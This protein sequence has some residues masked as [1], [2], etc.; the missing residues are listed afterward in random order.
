AA[1]VLF[2]DRSFPGRPVPE[3]SLVSG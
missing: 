1:R 2:G 3:P